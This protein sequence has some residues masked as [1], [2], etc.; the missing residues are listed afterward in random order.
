M[1]E[2]QAILEEYRASGVS[3]R[4]FCTDK[5]LGYASFLNWRKRLAEDS[6]TDPV[7]FIDLSSLSQPA[8]TS[9]WHIELE[10]GD[11]MTLRLD[12]R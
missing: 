7:S 11:G 10:L 6:N 3:A 12:R 4:Q 5:G 1:A 2:W 8:G 9:S